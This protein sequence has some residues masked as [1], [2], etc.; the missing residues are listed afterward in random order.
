MSVIIQICVIPPCDS[1]SDHH[2]RI[3][4]DTY[5]LQ[6]HHVNFED[7]Y[8]EI[9]YLYV[10]K[11]I[12]WNHCLIPITVNYLKFLKQF[13]LFHAWGTFKSFWFLVT[14]FS[15]GHGMVLQ[16]GLSIQNPFFER[17]EQEESNLVKEGYE[18][19]LQYKEFREH[20]IIGSCR[21]MWIDYLWKTLENVNGFKFLSASVVLDV[22]EIFIIRD[23]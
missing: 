22:R 13:Y 14:T 12:Q 9:H 17:N 20:R 6:R 23:K 19:K 3:D 18:Y 2:N 16:V 10:I 4:R 15:N 5:F 7:D 1:T 8:W 21:N 11:N